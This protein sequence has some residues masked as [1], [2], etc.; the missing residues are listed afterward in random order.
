[1]SI[2]KI[3][4]ITNALLAVVSGILTSMIEGFINSSY[5]IE[6]KKGNERVFEQVNE[7]SFVIQIIIT[8]LIFVFIWILLSLVIPYFISIIK[9]KLNY[10]TK[11]IYS[12]KYI[13]KVYNDVKNNWIVLM[14]KYSKL[15]HEDNS[16]IILTSDIFNCVNDLY[17]VFCSKNSKIQKMTVK[18]VFRN[19]PELYNIHRK[20]SPYEYN[21]LV[22]SMHIVC[23]NLNNNF[24]LNKSDDIKNLFDKD[25]INIVERLNSLSNI[26]LELKAMD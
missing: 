17:L 24:L 26:Y 20:I 19:K 11:R 14:D 8:I 1:M 22:S 4:S 10:R 16:V 23:E 21:S 7:Y 25:Y 9:R 13:I 6:T 15:D 5:F 2:T 3:K 18:S 12:D